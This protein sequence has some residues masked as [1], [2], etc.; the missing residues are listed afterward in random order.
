MSI[1]EIGEFG[2]I[3]KISRGC[4]IREENVFRAIGDDAAA[5]TTDPDDL[6]IV[7]TDMLIENVHFIREVTSGFNLG[8][9]ALAVNL[10]DIAAM[11]SV[12][13]E[14]FVSIGVP[15][16]VQSDYIEDMYNGIKSLAG[17]FGVNILGGDTTGSRHD[18]IINITIVGS[19]SKKEIL[20]RNTAKPGD[21]IFSTGF[22]GDSRAGLHLILNPE[23]AQADQFENLINAHLLPRPQI[24]EGRFLTFQKGVHAAIDISDGLSSDIGHIAK[25]SDVG[26]RL[27]AKKIPVSPDLADFC[28]QFGF[29]P[30]EYAL[31]GGEDYTLLCTISPE[32]A[33]QV[34]KDFQKEFKRCLYPLGEI[35]ET[36][37]MEL[38]FPD[39]QVKAIKPEGWDQFREKDNATITS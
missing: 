7:T 31:A 21:V 14:T 34:A 6:T 38:V 28:I 10:S 20:L 12:A 22:S 9:K 25:Q 23:A 3:K 36:K 8:Y 16:N 32:N 13:R 37:Q 30:I 4:L 26:V 18:L 27:E 19:V 39:G 5:F 17:E 1:K 29:D 35:T 2:L 11:G 33:D 15:D 24:G